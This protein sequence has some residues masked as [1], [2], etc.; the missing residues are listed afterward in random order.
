[1]ELMLK[2]NL[3]L[4]L[5]L[6]GHIVAK[7]PNIL[8]IFSDDHAY[9][10]ISA[11]GSNRNH[12]PNLDRL[13]NEGMR[14]DRAFVTNSICA[15]SRAVVLTGK[16]SHL[17]GQ[18]TNG[19]TFDGSQ[20]TFPKLLQKAGYQTALFGK[21]H[22]K[23]KPTGFDSWQV[24][25]GQGPYYNPLFRTPK[26]DRTTTGYTTDII[27]D[28]TLDW[29]KKE[30]NPDQPFFLCSWHKAPHRNWLP[31]PKYMKK[32][33]D[34]DIP[35]PET[36]RDNYQ[37]RL[38][39]ASTQA[40]TIEKH[41]H[42]DWDF[43][44]TA[45]RELNDEQKKIWN[46]AYEPKNKAFRESKLQGDDLLKW[47]YQRY[48]KDYLRCIDSVDENIGRLLDYLDQSGLAENTLV[49][50]SSDQGWYLG[51]HG[52]YDKRWM[53]EESFRTPLLARWPGV[54][55]P[56]SVNQDLVQNLDFA[57]TFLDLC[58]ADEPEDMQGRSLTPLLKG[59]T[60]ADWRKS[61]YYHYYE[62]PGS[63]NV[64]RHYGVRTHR[65]KLIHFYMI[66]GWELYDLQKD[67][68][69]LNSVYGQDGFEEI[70]TELKA[71]LARL[72]TQY[73]VPEDTRPL[74]KTIRE[75]Y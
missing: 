67:P 13:A 52:W 57:Q 35:E 20:Q 63:H 12:T 7:Q 54:I 58:G 65:Y 72:R 18:L 30:R 56:G 45:P 29:L 51:E 11:Y 50:Y 14:F 27:T 42:D 74:P 48:V 8:F 47:K 36:L 15:P 4:F 33:D 62:F 22:L 46:A 25:R 17:N 64:R 71:E 21:W 28:R 40:M 37:N 24:L 19:Q 23:S 1:M 66:D 55:Q 60:P 59:K 5:C 49:V 2:T 69:E 6:V 38:S 16:H 70:T 9:Q 39:P 61:I 41:M 3:P 73:Q 10:A 75:I 26:G 68:N 43:K 34:K 32:Y 53:Y 31:S 44:L